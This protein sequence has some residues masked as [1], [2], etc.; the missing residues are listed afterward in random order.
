[1]EYLFILIILII[2]TFNYDFKYQRKK[3]YDI[4][5]FI[6]LFILISLAGF[7]YKVGM[8]T[9]NYMYEFSNQIKVDNNNIKSIFFEGKRGIGIITIMS[10]FK[11]YFDYYIYQYF[12]AFVTVFGVYYF[13]KKTT[14]YIFF[15]LLI[16]YIFRYVDQ[17]FELMRET[18]A[19][20]LFLFSILSLNKNKYLQFAFFVFMAGLFHK[21]AFVLFLFALICK[22]LPSIKLQILFLNIVFFLFL[23]GGFANNMNDFLLMNFSDN[24][25]EIEMYMN[26]ELYNNA[27]LNFKG[28][29]ITMFY[30]PLLYYLV[31]QLKYNNVKTM[32][33]IDILICNVFCFSL[34]LIIS[35]FVPIFHRY[36]NYLSIINIVIISDYF[37]FL[38]NTK[39]FRIK[40][41][42]LALYFIVISISYKSD[43]K[44]VV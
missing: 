28:Y 38:K 30:L 24:I 34:I 14:Y 18:Y 27:N 1:M 40:T 39:H 17:S 9:Y 10:F 19:I 23:F 31:F 43:R 7:R 4:F 21:Y 8:D 6:S 20:V 36:N 15:S 25:A 3:G 32:L 11:T 37:L 13:F 41:N 16:F 29:I 2:G 5:I 33:N 42:V 12:T 35:R 22:Y 44:S 26:S